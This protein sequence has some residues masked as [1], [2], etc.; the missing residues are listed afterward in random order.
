MVNQQTL[1][2]NWNEIKGKLRTKWGQLT[3]DDVQ[4]FNGNVDQLVGTIQHR[5][6][7]TRNEIENDLE[8]ILA[9]G[10]SVVQKVTGAV[11]D[12]AHTAGEKAVAAYETV[13]ETVREG[14]E[15][16]EKVIQEHPGKSMAVAFGVG[17][18]SGGYGED[19]LMRA[20]AYRVYQDPADLLRHLDEVGVRVS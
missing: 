9:D 19:E 3:N 1:Q 15:A 12:A 4:S 11:K 13:S 5:T 17:L 10:G 16:T 18:L 20:G 6:G 2:G 8:D 7:K 14:Y